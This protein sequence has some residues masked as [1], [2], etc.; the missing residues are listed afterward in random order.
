[1]FLLSTFSL[2][3]TLLYRYEY[4]PTYNDGPHPVTA[5]SEGSAYLDFTTPCGSGAAQEAVY[6]F[7][8]VTLHPSP[9]N[10]Y[11]GS[12]PAIPSVTYSL[13]DARMSGVFDWDGN[14]LTGNWSLFFAT[15]NS[16]VYHNLFAWGMSS[17]W[18]G[19]YFFNETASPGRWV[20]TGSRSVP[21][22]GDTLAYLA[23]G[24]IVL[25]WRKA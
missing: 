23:I 18:P 22:A 17:F 1:M 25:L 21:E 13:S 12:L 15:A 20:F 9:S 5:G 10:F 19:E 2:L 3:A 11:G 14:Y 8:F 16:Q 6:D 7:A 4:T 24:A